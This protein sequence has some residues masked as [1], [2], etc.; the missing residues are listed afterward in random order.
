MSTFKHLS[1]N[2]LIHMTAESNNVQIVDI[3][4][5]AT[6]NAGHI[7]G[8]VNL[9]NENIASWMADADMDAPLVVVCYHGISSQGAANYLIEQGFDDVYS[10]DGGY[11]AWGE[12]HA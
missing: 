5:A 12:A 9:T 10:L 1:I 8:S 11:T 3:R 7:Q 6:F 2:D 4:D